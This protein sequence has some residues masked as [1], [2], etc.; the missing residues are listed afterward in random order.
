MSATFI[1]S[2]PES[3]LRFDRRE[4]TLLAC[5]H[6]YPKPMLLGELDGIPIV[7]AYR[8]GD[9]FHVIVPCPWCPPSRNRKRPFELH[10]HEEPGYRETFQ[11]LSHCGVIKKR[12][13]HLAIVG[14]WPWLKPAGGGR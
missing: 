7:A 14:D 13:I 12:Q 9:N 6:W 5:R 4:F 11:R 2:P 3:P 8:A 1:G 10:V